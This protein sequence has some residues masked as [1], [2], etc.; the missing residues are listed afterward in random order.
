MS[1]DVMYRYINIYAPAY[2]HILTYMPYKQEAGVHNKTPFGMCL[3]HK[4]T[5][6]FFC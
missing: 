3:T 6:H 4:F 2:L 5:C 1:V